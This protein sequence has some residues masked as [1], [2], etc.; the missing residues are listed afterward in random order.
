MLQVTPI[1]KYKNVYLKR[2]DY[3]K[4][5]EASGAKARVANA[6]CQQAKDTLILACSS[7]SHMPWIYG[8]VAKNYN[9]K[10]R[11]HI[12][13]VK[14]LSHELR[15][16]EHLVEFVQHSPG[17]TVVV[18]KRADQDFGFRVPKDGFCEV[19]FMFAKE[20]ALHVFEFAKENG[21]TRLVLPAGSGTVAT[22]VLL[23]EPPEW[24]EIIVV[25][26]GKNCQE[27]VLLNSKT[28]HK[29]LSFVT[30]S[31][32]YGT[33]VKHEFLDPIYEA[34]AFSLTQPGDIF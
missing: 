18:N 19:G 10:V 9:L 7:V 3:F 11:A 21:L 27:Q 26:T 17:Y 30:V 12:P 13:K 32:K 24:L 5:N 28:K 2:D 6:L 31:G 4:I 29:K 25:M 33:R 8:Q 22:G 23:A 1:E 34:R 16:A 15:A 14:Q 20:Q